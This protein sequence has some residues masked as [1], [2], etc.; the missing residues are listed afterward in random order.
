MDGVLAAASRHPRV[1]VGE[2]RSAAVVFGLL[3]AVASLAEHGPPGTR[4]VFYAGIEPRS[5]TLRAGSFPP[6]PPGKPR[7]AVVGGFFS[8]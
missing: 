6:E 2:G 1:V 5:P 3:L 4:G 7:Q 8:T